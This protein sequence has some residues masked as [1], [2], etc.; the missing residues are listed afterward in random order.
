MIA[1][2]MHF[3]HTFVIEGEVLNSLFHSSYPIKHCFVQLRKHLREQNELKDEVDLTQEGIN[4]SAED[5]P[6][7]KTCD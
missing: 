7:F 1:L 4:L 2:L 6:T 5:M 3:L